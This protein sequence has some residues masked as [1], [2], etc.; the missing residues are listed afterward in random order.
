MKVTV[1]SSEFIN[2]IP[3]TMSGAL[4]MNKIYNID[5]TFPRIIGKPQRIGIGLPD[6]QM[7][8][9]I[10]AEDDERLICLFGLRAEKPING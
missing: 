9:E 4:S 1:G 2:V 3:P 6:I 10:L 5:C 8:F 7:W